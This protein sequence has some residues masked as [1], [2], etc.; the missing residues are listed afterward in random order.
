MDEEKLPE[1][2]VLIGAGYIGMEFASLYAAFGSKVL[3]YGVFRIL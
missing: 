3:D 2:L 1:K